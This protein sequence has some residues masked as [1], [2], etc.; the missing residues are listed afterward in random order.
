MVG[1]DL[2]GLAPSVL[3]R[4]GSLE[5]VA[6]T[7]VEGF[8]GGLH[9]SPVKGFSVEFSEY[10]RY[11]PGDDPARIDWKLA[12][13][14]GRYYVKEFEE[15][16]NLECHLLLDISGSMGYG[17]QPV[18]KLQYGGFLAAALACLMHR[19]C[20][21]VGLMLF[22]DRV[23]ES[24]PVGSRSGHLQTLLSVL[25]KAKIGGKSDVAKPLDEIATRLRRRGLV[26]LISDLLD[27]PG[28]V[29]R[30]LKHLRFRGSEVIV[31]HVLDPAE[32]TFPFERVA[33]F[34]DMETASQVIAVPSRVR[35][36]YLKNSEEQQERYR[37]EL[38]LA[39]IDYHLV[40]TAKPFDDALMSYLSTRG[41]RA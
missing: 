36:C 28:A 25:S 19:Q 17:S 31:F 34:E 22:D 27:D 13:R 29:I 35:Q 15:E 39:N 10:R 7:I 16:T 24:V 2:S 26:V 12:A 3:V 23:I 41:R 30:G 4:L 38:R 5:L 11:L 18:T 37:R 14:S 40:N 32:L 9:R 20:D 8:L 33:Q 6:R 21:G 1:S